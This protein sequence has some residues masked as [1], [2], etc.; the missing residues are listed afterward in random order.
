ML[1][2]VS[3]NRLGRQGFPTQLGPRCDG[4][5]LSEMG[6]IRTS[7]LPWT[8][9]R[10]RIGGSELK[11]LAKLVVVAG[12]TLATVVMAAHP[13][14]GVA[15]SAET[16][17]TGSVEVTGRAETRV[18]YRVECPSATGFTLSVNRLPPWAQTARQKAKPNRITGL[19]RS[20]RI[21]G[22]GS[23]PPASAHCQKSERIGRVECDVRFTG[24]AVLTGTITTPNGEA[25]KMRIG[26]TEHHG[27]DTPSIVGAELAAPRRPSGCKKRK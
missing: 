19:D 4:S 13:P 18:R 10:G 1:R 12:A 11:V 23:A 5:G 25:C 24:P 3:T 21:R 6:Y 2:W 7:T 22:A 15:Q 26:L 27:A 20:P 14:V 16:S 9:R 8:T 17:C